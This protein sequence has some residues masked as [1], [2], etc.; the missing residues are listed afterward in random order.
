[1]HR[2]RDSIHFL[3]SN[4][5]TWFGGLVICALIQPDV[6]CRTCTQ[7]FRTED[8]GGGKENQGFSPYLTIQDDTQNRMN[9]LST[10]TQESLRDI[11]AWYHPCTVRGGESAQLDANQGNQGADLSPPTSQ[12]LQVTKDLSSSAT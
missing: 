11:F 6:S 5:N 4:L 3:L 9:N 10:M 1:M 12:A 7:S 8:E 2:S